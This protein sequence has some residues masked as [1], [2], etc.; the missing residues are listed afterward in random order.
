[1]HRWMERLLVT[2]LTGAVVLIPAH[3]FAEGDVTVTLT[4]NRMITKSGG[5]EVAAPA[6]EA[7]P[8]DVIEYR[9]SYRNPG[10]SRVHGV[11]ATLPI[12]AGT[13]Y[14]AHSASPAAPLAS[15]DGLT[16]A[17]TP[18]TRRVRLADGHEL[19]Q[20]IPLAEY[21]ALRWTLGNLAAHGQ[22]VVRARV[23]V[24]PVAVAAN[25]TH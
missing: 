21:R 12:P 4:A 1:M 23:R 7:R 19:I 11:S 14:V 9:A 8:G 20:E 3:A 18:L 16:F 10:D 13:E 17:P 24:T 2:V 6:T 5:A 22:Q 15:L 25:T